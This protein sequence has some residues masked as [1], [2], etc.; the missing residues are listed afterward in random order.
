MARVKGIGDYRKV[1]KLMD[2][3]KLLFEALKIALD[4][5]KSDVSFFK[6]FNR[7]T[8]NRF[9]KLSIEVFGIDRNGHTHCTGCI[10]YS[11]SVEAVSIDD[12]IKYSAPWPYCNYTPFTE[13]D[14]FDFQNR[15]IIEKLRS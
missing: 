4:P 7:W 12:I 9:N 10:L 6:P 14:W 2:K 13:Q 5:Y 8:I 15:V 1:K 11:S 3:E